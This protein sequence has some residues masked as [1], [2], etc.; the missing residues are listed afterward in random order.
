M[1]LT[2]LSV[3]HLRNL[4]ALQIEPA[5]GLN[6]IT[7][8]NAEGK[9]SLLE[10]IF[11]L[12]MGRSF[13]S[14]NVRHVITQGES[15][16]LVFGQISQDGNRVNLGVEKQRERTRIKVAGEWV[17]SASL[18]A[19]HL[20]LQLITPDSHKLIEQGP[21][22][23][24]QFVDWGV[25]HVEPGFHQ[26]WQRFQRALK[27][28]NAG[29]RQGL[30]QQAMVTWN[31]ELVFHVEQIDQMRR[32]YVQDL[33]PIA[34]GGIQALTDLSTV[35]IA[36]Q[37]GWK[38]GLGYAEYLD[39]QFELDREAGYTR[40]GPHRAEVSIRV[41]GMPAAERVS[42]GQQKL[43]ASALRLAQIQL[44]KQRRDIDPVLLVDDLPAELDSER[45]GRFLEA[46]RLLQTQVFV[47]ATEADLI[48][49]RSAWESR[50][51]FHLE[52]GEV[53]EV[54]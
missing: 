1:S 25:F 43:L 13:R 40:Y 37:S 34:L 27:Q 2:R 44:L 24:R 47:T 7:G 52:H 31:R 51:S 14:V 18:L 17:K 53:T 15:A 54:V 5:P 21:R 46:L 48:S 30:S 16:L 12:G 50:K 35:E 6:L 29:L 20:P 42:R 10:A 41:E 23:R 19:Q 4:H 11:L 9:T 33:L 45:R 26:V 38:Q 32:Q 22:Y 8:A 39:S 3:K 49:N 36:Y 28:R